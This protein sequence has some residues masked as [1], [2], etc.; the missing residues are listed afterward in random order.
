MTNVRDS[1]YV[2]DPLSIPEGEHWAIIRGT[3]TFVPGDERS[4]QYPGHGYPEHTEHHISYQV[5]FDEK[6]FQE[7]LVRGQNL[8]FGVKPVR[9]IHVTNTYKPVTKVEVVT[10]LEK[11]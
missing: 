10:T 3:S 7:E 5:F 9:G 6:K 2:T 11:E 1:F 4:K 8:A